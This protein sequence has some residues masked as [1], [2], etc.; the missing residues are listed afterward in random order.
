M[1][2]FLP[3]HSRSAG[4]ASMQNLLTPD[5]HSVRLTMAG[6][7]TVAKVLTKDVPLFGISL[8]RFQV[9]RAALRLGER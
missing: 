8:P 3:K 6:R 1:L 9:N 5:Q 4:V 7:M 2:A